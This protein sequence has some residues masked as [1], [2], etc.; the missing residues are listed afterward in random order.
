VVGK[1]SPHIYVDS[2]VSVVAKNS[3]E[4]LF[5]EIAL[6]IHLGLVAITFRLKGSLERNMNLARIIFNKLAATPHFQV[7]K[8]N[9]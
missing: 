8:N 3:E 4:T 7:C 5:Q 2:K 6:A 1:L 9:F